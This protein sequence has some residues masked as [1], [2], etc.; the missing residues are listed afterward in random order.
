MEDQLAKLYKVPERLRALLSRE[1]G[2]LV[3]GIDRLLVAKRVVEIACGRRLWS[4]GDVI[5]ISLVEID[6][7]PDVAIIDRATL[8]EKDIDTKHIET[9]YR[10]VGEILEIHNPRGHIS[11]EAILTI[12]RL[13]SR[14]SGKHLVLV[15]GEEDLLSLAIA[16][17]ARLGEALAYGIPSRGASVV[18]IDHYI[19]DLARD[20]MKEI[21]GEDYKIYFE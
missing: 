3:E 14:S 11:A 10:E 20:L 18:I 6:Y 2:H 7:I 8:R 1:Y 17:L 15:R 19:R 13:A 4:V 21:L 9:K 12:K 16:S 5:S